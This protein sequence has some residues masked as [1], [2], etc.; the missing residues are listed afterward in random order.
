[1]SNAR[2]SLLPLK[3][4][5]E[6]GV[7]FGMTCLESK[8]LYLFV[9]QL[10]RSQLE[11]A[12]TIVECNNTN[13]HNTEADCRLIFESG[14][15]FFSAM[16]VLF[17]SQRTIFEQNHRCYECGKDWIEHLQEFDNEISNNNKN[18]DKNNINT[19]AIDVNDSNSG[20]YIR[21]KIDKLFSIYLEKDI[22]IHDGHNVKIAVESIQFCDGLANAF[23]DY[24]FKRA[25]FY[26]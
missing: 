13:E 11:V 10:L 19:Q 23:G 2:F 12:D 7:M 6:S 1:M 24:L 5:Y 21:D 18:N 17:Y 16:L 26:S 8:K 22:T 4:C 20:M 15:Y 14:Q 9:Y 3:Q 25:Y